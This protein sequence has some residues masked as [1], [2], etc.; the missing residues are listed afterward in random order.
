M[1]AKFADA[2]T[3]DVSLVFQANSGYSA[4]D[5]ITLSNYIT[6]LNVQQ[7]KMR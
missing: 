2:E 6:A 5:N 3:V 4:A 7:E 1:Y